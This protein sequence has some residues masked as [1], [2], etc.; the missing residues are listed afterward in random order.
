MASAA[1]EHFENLLTW[2]V[3]PSWVLMRRGRPILGLFA[4]AAVIT[5]VCGCG[6]NT[7]TA[8]NNVTSI[9]IA[10]TTSSTQ[11]GLNEQLTFNATVTLTNSTITTNTAVTW[12]V[13]G[14]TGG[15]ATTGTIA[16]SST[17]V[18]QGVYTAPGKIPSTNINITAIIV[19]T[20]NS[21]STS[22]VTITSNTITVSIG[23]GAGLTI[24]PTQATVPAGGTY[25]FTADLNSV[26]DSSATW[27][28]SSTNG[29]DIGSINPTTGLYT[30]PEAPPPGGEVT[31]TATDPTEATTPAT[32]TARIVYSDAS[33]RGP[34][35][36]SYVGDDATGFRAV[37]GRFVADGAGTIQGG[38]EDVDSFGSPVAPAVPILSGTYRVGPDGR[39]SAV[40]TTDHGQETWQFVLTST[41]HALLI[42]FDSSTTGHGTIDQQNLNDLSNAPSVI[43]GNYVFRAAGGDLQF[44]PLGVAGRFTA[45]GSG[46]IPQTASIVDE[47]DNGTVKAADTTLSG[48]YSFDAAN[49]GTGRGTIT[50]SS[51][52]TGQL[53]FAFYIIDNTHF[54]II[55]TDSAAYLA[56]SVFSG[57]TG[58]S[59]GNSELSASN[60]VFTVGGNSTSG[61]YAA[62]GVFTSDSNGNITGGTLD[63]DNAGTATANT[64]ISPSTYSVDA[65][66]GRVDL[67]LGSMEFAAYPTA[68]NTALVL[69]LDS[70][71]IAGGAAYL[72][73]PS[74]AALAG[75]YALAL[76]GQG[77]FYS[78]PGL[79][80]SD[81][82]GEAAFTGSV[83]TSGSANLDINNYGTSPQSS[84]PIGTSSTISAPGTNGRGTATLQLNDPPATYN[85]VYYV[86]DANTAVVVGQDTTRVLDGIVIHQ[87]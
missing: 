87:F 56:G 84:D 64:S 66:T 3:G 38:L 16:D 27:S 78:D 35:A 82:E 65:A 24:T 61:A 19:E 59:F 22:T 39:T 42:R 62:G 63:S 74:P 60:Y 43:K 12:Q 83:F 28:V 77:I 36:F 71:A 15:N 54:Y 48:S 49:S 30:A 68:A 47:N 31:V 9:S 10:P 79:Y 20:P 8:N 25:Q 46:G 72:Q 53:M 18:N 45:D 29:G 5:A 17:A 14:T 40:V 11:V 76:N 26:V 52:S 6:S 44:H 32:A 50:L 4:C 37:A 69:E 2:L 7:V 41:T 73:Q 67:K 80:Q 34:F 70:T 13:N 85:L 21:G 55:E 81:A 58:S 57:A 33:L 75:N 1:R 51:T 23:S 86:I